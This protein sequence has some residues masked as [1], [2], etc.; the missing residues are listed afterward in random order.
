MDLS[1]LIPSRNEG[2]YL[3]SECNLAIGNAEDSP[4]RLRAMA[5]Y[6]ERN[7]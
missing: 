3:N 4:D 5:D 7:R 1:I 2:D 6:L